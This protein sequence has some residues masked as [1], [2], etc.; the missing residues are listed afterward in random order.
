[1]PA[2]VTGILTICAL[3]HDCERKKKRKAE[4]RQT[5]FTKTTAPSGAAR[6]LQGALAHRR[7]TTALT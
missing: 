7:S 4:R 1:M 2:V 5:L 3:S 6:A